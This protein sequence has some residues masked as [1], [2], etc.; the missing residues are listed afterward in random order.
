MFATIVVGDDDIEGDLWQVQVE[1]LL[2]VPPG[3][4]G[5]Q[6]ATDAGSSA[7]RLANAVME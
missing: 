1:Y 6:A 5:D 4:A 3:R 7:Q 2:D